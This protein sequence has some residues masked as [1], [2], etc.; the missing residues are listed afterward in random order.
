MSITHAI[1]KI[2]SA[3]IL[4]DFR[5][6]AIFAGLA[7]R[8]YEGE[9]KSGNS[10]RIPGIEPIEIHDYKA[11]GRTTEPDEVSDT[12]LDLLIDQE[13]SF[14]FIVD[15]I[16]A[17]QASA[18]LMSA[19]TQSAADGLVEDSDKFLAALAIA[20][21]TAVTPGAPVTSAE[22]AWNAIRDLRKALNKAK[23]PQADRLLIV[24]A[25]FASYLEEYE[26]K[27]MAVDTSGDSSG[28]REATIGKLLGFTTYNS[29]NV[30]TTNKPQM[31]GF[32]RSSIAFVSQ[33][34]ATE[35]MRAEKKHA[36]RLRGL[37]VYGGK[38]IRPTAV[39]T[40]TGA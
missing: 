13:K 7:N 17:A 25:E 40:Y 29:E 11:A 9:L 22:T 39:V 20:N 38:V 10:I 32:H 5:E 26:S 1:P 4:T 28:L 31:I 35:A 36:D 27:I 3:K 33:I 14:D 18:P 23:V 19:Y 15:D 37:H 21:G 30:P 16:D 8:E 12:G 6:N 2:W 24:N 34:S